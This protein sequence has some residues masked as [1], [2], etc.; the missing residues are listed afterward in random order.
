MTTPNHLISTVGTSLLS[1]LRLLTP[2][3]T[4]GHN[5]DIVTTPENAVVLKQL[6]E[7]KN[8]GQ[9]VA[10]LRSEFQPSDK[11]LGAEINTITELI[12]R[13][14]VT[15]DATLHFCVSDT[16]DGESV[17]EILCAY[18]KK[19][20]TNAHPVKI[21]GLQSNKPEDFSKVGLRTLVVEICAITRKAGG[22][23]FVALNATGGY[24]AQIALAAVIGQTLGLPVYYKHEQFPFITA[25]APM[26]ITFDYD[27]IAERAD[28]FVA[29]D[30]ENSSVDLAAGDALDER[31]APLLDEIT[32]GSQKCCAFSAMGRLYWEGYKLRYP[33]QET[34]PSA[35]TKREAPNFRD[36]NFPDGFKDFVKAV[37]EKSPYI[38]TTH[39]EEYSGQ[40]AIRHGRFYVRLSD[41]KIIGEFQDKNSFGA[42]FS[43]TTTAKTS[44]QKSAVARDLN[45]RFGKS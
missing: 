37:W 30:E 8:W 10:R 7:Q 21:N 41:A 43:L 9:L 3:G 6:Y 38:E 24:K 40:R 14:N 12:A 42:R 1:N 33:L 23:S 17:G 44:L 11:I 20:G 31:F 34:L 4:L 32:I 2:E 16:P 45:E 25:L 36:D 28:D 15:R 29:L 5:K 13:E 18:Y 35:A 19:A 27:L 26:P 22:S 39:S